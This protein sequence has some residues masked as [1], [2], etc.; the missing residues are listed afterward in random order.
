MFLPLAAIRDQRL[1]RPRCRVAGAARPQAP[2]PRRG[3]R[4]A[5]RSGAAGC[6]SWGPAC[7]PCLD[8][9]VQGLGIRLLQRG[10]ETHSWWVRSGS[11][12]DTARR[13]PE[14]WTCTWAQCCSAMG[15][16]SAS[17]GA[18]LKED[19]RVP[20]HNLHTDVP[21]QNP[22]ALICIAGSASHKRTLG[23]PPIR[24][25]SSKI[26]KR[27]THKITSEVQWQDACG[28]LTSRRARTAMQHDRKQ[29]PADPRR[30]TCRALP[31]A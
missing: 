26:L 17:A 18:H 30:C 29:P 24:V 3:M 13:G 7:S 10:H 9:K 22:Q 1:H 21:S 15:A 27:H 5:P 4:H 19:N 11:R 23:I 8:F 20:H 16:C 2:R 25:V 12:G 6:A 28:K 14:R 31:Q